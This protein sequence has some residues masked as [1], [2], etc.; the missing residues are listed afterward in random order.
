MLREKSLERKIIS[1]AGYNFLADALEIKRGILTVGTDEGKA[2]VE[3]VG[4]TILMGRMTDDLRAAFISR[5][6]DLRS[7][8]ARASR[9]GDN[10]P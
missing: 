8:N 5:A 1:S 9:M 10:V 3:E 4:Q 7:R 2:L 6:Q